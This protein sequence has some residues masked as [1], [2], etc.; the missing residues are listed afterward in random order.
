MDPSL[1]KLR[2][3][4][5]DYTGYIDWVQNNHGNLRQRI[6]QMEY[7]GCNEIFK[8]YIVDPV[9]YDTVVGQSKGMVNVSDTMCAPS[10]WKFAFHWSNGFAETHFSL[11]NFFNVSWVYISFGVALQIFVWAKAEYF[12]FGLLI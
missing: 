10:H 3:T 6:V 2:A 4:E 5:Q 1:Q 8:R 7:T 11:Y 9:S 12:S